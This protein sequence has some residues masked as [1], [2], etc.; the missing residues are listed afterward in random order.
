ML[1]KRENSTLYLLILY[2]SAP[3]S[4]VSVP[5]LEPLFFHVEGFSEVPL[6]GG[7]RKVDPG[8]LN[9]VKRSM[10]KGNLDVF[11]ALL[12]IALFPR[13]Y[14]PPSLPQIGELFHTITEDIHQPRDRDWVRCFWE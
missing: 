12:N 6:K 4:E 9:M 13:R 11:I 10:S 7:T 3:S 8:P 14:R 2:Y 1:I 5:N